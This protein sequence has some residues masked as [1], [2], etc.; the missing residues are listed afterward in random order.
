MAAKLD[1][2]GGRQNAPLLF[3]LFFTATLQPNIP[4]YLSQIT[5]R[6]VKAHLFLALPFLPVA[7]KLLHVDVEGTN[8]MIRKQSGDVVFICTQL[9][10]L[11]SKSNCNKQMFRALL[12]FVALAMVAAFSPVRMVARSNMA[13][14]A[15]TM[16]KSSTGKTEC[17]E[18]K[19]DKNGRCP[20]ES[21][22][23]SF[24]KSDD[25]SFAQIQADNAAKKAAAGK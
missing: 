1:A 5:K 20:G 25:R 17:V 13:I 10:L 2:W 9:Q 12:V 6:K 15:E 22:Y 8:S 18:Y 19:V 23:V 7:P 11:P 21:G 14:S 3:D 16:K 24:T 4:K